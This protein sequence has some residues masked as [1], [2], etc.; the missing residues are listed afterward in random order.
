MN[1]GI[2]GSGNVGGTL[3]QRLAQLGHTVTFGSRNPKSA[4]IETLLQ[5][6]GANALAATLPEA[7]AESDVILVT[8]PW[9]ATRAVL[10]SLDLKDKVVLDCTNPL[11]P[12]LAGIEIG[13][14]GSGG[15]QVALWA[16]GASVVKLFNTT[17]YN[18][19]ANPRYGDGASVMFY[20]GDDPAAK[21]IAAQLATELGFDAVDSGPLA[22]ARLLEPTAMLWIWL[23]VFG[24][25]GRDFAFQLV[26]R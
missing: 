21:A 11:L 10:E 8:L 5:Q 25:L 18:N 20:C 9:P 12:N 19:M 6:A 15:E 17:G 2:L 7:V 1:I 24:G 23:A 26:K 3:G 4:E 14:T 16:P 13:T 22:N